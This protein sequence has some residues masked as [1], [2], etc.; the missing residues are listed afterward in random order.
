MPDYKAQAKSWCD[1]FIAEQDIVPWDAED[2]DML[3]KLLFLELVNQIEPAEVIQQ[4][5]NSAGVRALYQRTQLRDLNISTK[6][7]FF[8]SAH[9][10]MPG[11][12][13]MLV[14][15]MWQYSV[16]HNCNITMQN[17]VMLWPNGLPSKAAFDRHWAAQK[18]D[19][20]NLLDLVL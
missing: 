19:G 7:M 20:V 14:E 5:F 1:N 17:V 3:T 12:I 16:E 4:L 8:L 10:A 9:A 6:V 13:A 18:I 11:E 2:V 15:A